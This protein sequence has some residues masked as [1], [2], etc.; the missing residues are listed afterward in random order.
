MRLLRMAL[1]LCLLV[2]VVW[3]EFGTAEEKITVWWA[4]TPPLY[5]CK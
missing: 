3:P 1:G 4:R 5:T 2:L